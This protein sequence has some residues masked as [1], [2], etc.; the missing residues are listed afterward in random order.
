MTLLRR[1]AA[2]ALGTAGLL[3]AVVGSGIMGERLA[4][5]NAALALL[6]N[7]LATGCALWVAIAVLAPFSGAHFNP[8]VTVHAAARGEL[9]WRDVVPYAAVQCA[10]AVAGVALANLMFGLPAWSWS[11]RVRTGPGQWTGEI[12]AT[13]GLLLV[14]RFGRSASLPALV[15]VY[16]AGAYWFTSSTSFANPAVALARALT[17]TFAGIRPADVPGFIASQ[18]A[19]ALLAF[20]MARWLAGGVADRQRP[21]T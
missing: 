3:I 14:V 10:A 15:A 4:G 2:E 13:F 20:A 19:G 21:P 12:I 5:G 8:L 1:L 17:D 16:I 18:L 11:Q 6:A 9:A 7:S